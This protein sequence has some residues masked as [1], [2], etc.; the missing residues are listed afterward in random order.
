M[1]QARH[2]GI[3]VIGDEELVSG[4]RLAGTSRYYVI[5]G[6]HDIREEVAKALGELIDEPS[7]AVIVIMEDYAEYVEDLLASVRERKGMTPVIIEVPSKFGTKYTDIVGYYRA[8]IKQSTG[9]DVE[10]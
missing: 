9:F 8:F 5:K 10:I 6:S 7:I 3:A 1:T 4:L 2:P